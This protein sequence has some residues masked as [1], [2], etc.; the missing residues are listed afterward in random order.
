MVTSEEQREEVARARGEGFEVVH[1]KPNRLLLDLDSLVAYKTYIKNRKR[2]DNDLDMECVFFKWES[3]SNN[4]HVM[5]SLPKELPVMERL[6]LQLYL[7]SDPTK[8]F[9]SYIRHL[10]SVDSELVSMLFKPGEDDE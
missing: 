1:G 2:L 3:K 4:R 5:I 9:L 10:N 7:G 6:F 8:E